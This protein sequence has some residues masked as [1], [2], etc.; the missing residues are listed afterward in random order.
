M[1]FGKC[2]L[3]AFFLLSQTLSQA[4]L[5]HESIHSVARVMLLDW[6]FSPAN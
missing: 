6:P 2:D 4:Q 3:D 5:T 1:C